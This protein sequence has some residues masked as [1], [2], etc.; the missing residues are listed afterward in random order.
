V[1]EI[2]RM[3]FT[4]KLSFLEHLRVYIAIQIRPPWLWLYL[5]IPIAGVLPNV[6]QGRS[7]TS[8]L[9]IFLICIIASPI[10]LFL[11]SL[12][13]TLGGRLN[14]IY[15]EPVNFAFDDESMGM[16]T[17]TM[18]IEY[19]WTQIQQELESKDFFV[20]YFSALGGMGL[21]RSTNPPEH[22]EPLRQLVRSKIGSKAKF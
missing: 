4:Q 12:V 8:L 11:S 19:K 16:Q 14:A 1:I 17:S 10:T 20:F 6:I 18:K 7:L 3:N 15:R 13:G 5:L 9:I 2:L 22:I 21:Y